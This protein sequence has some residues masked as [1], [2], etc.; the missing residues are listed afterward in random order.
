MKPHRLKF[1]LVF[2]LLSVGICMLCEIVAVQAGPLPQGYTEREMFS[3]GAIKGQE[4][5]RKSRLRQLRIQE[6]RMPQDVKAI[7]LTTMGTPGD[8][9]PEIIG[10]MT[11][12]HSRFVAGGWMW[13]SGVVYGT[14]QIKGPSTGSSYPIGNAVEYSVTDPESVHLAEERPITEWWEFSAREQRAEFFR[15]RF[16]AAQQ[17]QT[18]PGL[19][20]GGAGRTGMSPSDGGEIGGF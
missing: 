4:F 11:R 1:Y 12:D 18:M 16:G 20:E 15:T 8:S 10:A 13:N 5:R 6:S 9:R 19:E 7:A 3:R 17:L 2:G 14:A